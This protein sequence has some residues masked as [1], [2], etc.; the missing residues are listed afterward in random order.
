MKTSILVLATAIWLASDV[1]MHGADKTTVQQAVAVLHPTAGQHCHGVVHFTQ[2]SDS[3]KVV[4]DVE[5][6]TPGQKH[7]FTYINM[8]T[9]RELTV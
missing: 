9:A 6:L 1:Y 3:V 4:A 8:G 7:A 2:D 5:G